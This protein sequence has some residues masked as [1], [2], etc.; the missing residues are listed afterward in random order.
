MRISLLSNLIK[1]KHLRIVFY[2][3][4]TSFSTISFAQSHTVSL[5]PLAGAFGTARVGYE[6]TPQN[7][8][9]SYGILSSVY[10]QSFLKDG[11]GF[12]FSPYLRIYFHPQDRWYFR[13]RLIVGYRD[14][15]VSYYTKQVGFFGSNIYINRTYYIVGGGVAF[16]KQWIVK[17]NIT[18]DLLLGVKGFYEGFQ[19]EIQSQ[20][21]SYS[22]R[23]Y[24]MFP[25]FVRPLQGIDVQFSI[26]YTFHSN[27]TRKF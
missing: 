16:G 9:L 11:Y 23:E 5:F 8:L 19:K 2:L 7:S 17:D 26:G 3:I 24:F 27:K 25:D 18:F 21:Y 1:F 14:R 20:S 12:D 15:D 22:S 6:Y 4:C 10:F 13:P